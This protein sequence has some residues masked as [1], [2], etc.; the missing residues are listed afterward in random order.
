MRN[1]L[2]EMF[3]GSRNHRNLRQ[4]FAVKKSSVA[5]GLALIILIGGFSIMTVALSDRFTP[6]LRG[7]EISGRIRDMH[8]RP[9]AALK[10]SLMNWFGADLGSAV[11]DDQG[12]FHIQN[13]APGSYYVKFRLLAEDSRG[14][15]MIIQVPAHPMRMNL[16]VTRNPS[17]MASLDRPAG[18]SIDRLA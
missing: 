13:V 3:T 4:R 7:T 15:T 6:Q 9:V 16:T 2:R 10:I 14:E 8:G 12:I 17:A 18:P 5:V 11:S 1:Y